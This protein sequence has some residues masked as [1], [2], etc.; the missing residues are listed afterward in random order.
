MGIKFVCEQYKLLWTNL[1]CKTNFTGIQDSEGG[2]RKNY[3]P[4]IWQSINGPYSN[5]PHVP[6]FNYVSLHRQCLW[7]P[8]IHVAHNN[9]PLPPKTKTTKTRLS[10]VIL[11]YGQTYMR[12]F[13]VTRPTL[14]LGPYPWASIKCETKSTKTKR[15]QRKQNEVTKKKRNRLIWTKWKENK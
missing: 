5:T 7:D 6:P 4:Y 3:T 15:N 1:V 14:M 13:T 10:V 9:T 2:G 8:N 12:M 11:F